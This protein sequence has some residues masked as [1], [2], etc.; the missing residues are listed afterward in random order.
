V[1]D[2][3][4]KSKL[5]EVASDRKTQVL[6]GIQS[7]QLMK[8][9]LEFGSE[10]P[11]NINCYNHIEYGITHDFRSSAVLGLKLKSKDLLLSKVMNVVENL[12]LPNEVRKEFPDLTDSEW[13]AITR[14]VNRNTYSS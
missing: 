7:E 13:D 6:L 3:S 8:A 11:D 12:E 14:M 2:N 5:F 9:F 10:T 1:S 4:F